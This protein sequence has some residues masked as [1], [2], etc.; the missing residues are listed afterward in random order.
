MCIRQLIKPPCS[1]QSIDQLALAYAE[2]LGMTAEDFV[3]VA[4]MIRR[5][6]L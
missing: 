5:G 1:L 2:C 4:K 3:K 6:K